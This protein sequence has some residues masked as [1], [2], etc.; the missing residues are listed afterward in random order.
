ML[1]TP[2]MT[3]HK[4]IN[5]QKILVA[6]DL[7]QPFIRTEIRFGIFISALEPTAHTSIQYRFRIWLLC[8]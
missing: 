8:S 7:S 5:I 3:A 1:C 2:L 6:S 4:K